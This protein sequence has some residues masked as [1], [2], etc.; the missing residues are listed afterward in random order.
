MNRGDPYVQEISATVSAVMDVLR[1]PGAGGVTPCRDPTGKDQLAGDGAAIPAVRSPYVLA[2]QSK[3]G[4]LPWMGPPTASVLAGLGR[5]GHQYVLAVPIAF[6]SD[7]V[8]TLFEIDI[9]YAEDA[10]KAGILQFERAPSLNGEPLLTAAQAEL[11]RDHLAGGHVSS[12]QY[13]LNC[14]GCVNP[15][16][17][18]VLNPVGEDGRT[19]GAYAKLRDSYT[20]GGC[21]A[22]PGSPWP[23]AE[24]TVRLKALGTEPNK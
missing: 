12:P 20:P 21:G 7:H 18:S 16:C 14:A 8:E 3:V 22:I 10:H 9:E 24:E 4:F 1:S 5:Q 13:P 17:R 15:A 6:T 23:T 19:P 2:W 11:V